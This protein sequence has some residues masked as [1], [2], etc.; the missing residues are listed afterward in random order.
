MKNQVSHAVLWLPYM[1]CGTDSHIRIN[2]PKQHFNWGLERRLRGSVLA[3]PG[4]STNHYPS[5]RSQSQLESAP[6]PHN[7][8]QMKV[9]SFSRCP[10]SS[11]EECSFPCGDSQGGSK[12]L[13]SSQRA[14]TDTWPVCALLFLRS[15]SHPRPVDSLSCHHH[16]TTD[17]F[18][19]APAQ[20][21]QTSLYCS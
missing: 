3:C 20:M 14:A 16:E 9:L 17:P 12:C 7:Q 4:L 8:P 15:V 5:L 18:P 6:Y 1:S 2:A 11:P 19:T 13:D 21:V 10:T